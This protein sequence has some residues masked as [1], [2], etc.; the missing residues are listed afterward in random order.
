METYLSYF[1][2]NQRDEVRIAVA[3]LR[4]QALQKYICHPNKNS[5]TWKELKNILIQTYKSIDYQTTLRRKL[6]TLK[7]VT[8]VECYIQEFDKTISQMDSRSSSKISS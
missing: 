2:L 7:Q 8:S 1:R 4:E 3:Y 6:T 5:M